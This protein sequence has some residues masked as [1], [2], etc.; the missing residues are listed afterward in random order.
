MRRELQV[1]GFLNPNNPS[2]GMNDRRA[3]N[4]EFLLEYIVAILKK[5]DSESL[6]KQFKA[7]LQS[8]IF[9]E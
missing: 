1:F 3:N 9:F 5:V 8:F 4:A 7:P 6:S 2:T